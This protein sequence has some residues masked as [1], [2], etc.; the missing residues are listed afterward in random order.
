M[1]PVKRYFRY[2]VY[3]FIYLSERIRGIDFIMRK[4]NAQMYNT[5]CHGY[6]VTPYVHLRQVLTYISQEE[7]V[8]FIDIG[9]GKGIVLYHATKLNFKAIMGIDYDYE[10]IR[11]AKR[12]FDKLK[13]NKV[14]LLSTDATAFDRYSDFN[15]FYFNNPFS[16][17][18]FKN[19]LNNIVNSLSK[20]KRNITIICYKAP[21]YEHELLKNGFEIIHKIY[22][23]I[24]ETFTV[25]YRL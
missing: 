16:V 19:V 4:V 18:I 2:T 10:L 21:Y 23:N 13:I 7:E 17:E 9:C 24:K 3:M 22:D 12:N 20:E 6:N 15:Y 5:G 25:F 8:K 14:E 11:L 1:T